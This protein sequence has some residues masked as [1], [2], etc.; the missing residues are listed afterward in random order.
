MYTCSIMWKWARC[1]CLCIVVVPGFFC[2][3]ATEPSHG[4]GMQSGGRGE[5]Q[6]LSCSHSPKQ[7]CT[8][9]QVE[10][11]SARDVGMPRLPGA[12]HT[13]RP[14][15][16]PLPPVTERKSSSSGV[17]RMRVKGARHTLW[18]FTQPWQ[19]CRTDCVY[20]QC[21]IKCMLWLI[22]S[23]VQHFCVPKNIPII[24]I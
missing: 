21:K 12:T 2:S 17:V 22:S 6:L 19:S 10:T 9:E 4:W 24:I 23:R 5:F 20:C 11:P 1:V 18:S 16:F 15:A 7:E 3:S 14:N 13:T 8:R